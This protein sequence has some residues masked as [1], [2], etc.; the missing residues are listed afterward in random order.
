VTGHRDHKLVRRVLAGN[1]SAAEELARRGHAD[2]Y[3]FFMW[4]TRDADLA[5]NLTQDTFVRVWERLSQYRGE[6]SLRTWM[7]TIAYSVLTDHRRQETRAQRGLA[8][9]AQT[10]P[11]HD[12]PLRQAELRMALAEALGALPEPERSVIILCKLRGFT[13]AEAAGLL[14]EPVGTLAWRVAEGLKRLHGLLSGEQETERKT[15]AVR[16]KETDPDVSQGS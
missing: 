6:S 7:H 10:R 12:E 11:P 15:T 1:A 9:Y 16:G 3:Q 13:L 8:E 2:L 4:Q 5:A 14:G